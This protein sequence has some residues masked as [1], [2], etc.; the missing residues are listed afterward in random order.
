MVSRFPLKK[1]V[2]TMRGYKK[3]LFKIKNAKVEWWKNCGYKR[4]AIGTKDT[5]LMTELLPK[6]NGFKFWNSSIRHNS[7]TTYSTYLNQRYISKVPWYIKVLLWIWVDWLQTSLNI[8]WS[9]GITLKKMLK[10]FEVK[11]KTNENQKYESTLIKNLVKLHN[12]FI[13]VPSYFWFRTVFFLTIAMISK[14][15]FKIKNRRYDDENFGQVA[16]THFSSPYSGIFDFEQ[17]F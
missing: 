13:S 7:P 14:K 16:R 17:F 2:E 11:K 15:L 4:K 8:C 5:E 6:E 3:K 12:F 1:N 10:P 9:L